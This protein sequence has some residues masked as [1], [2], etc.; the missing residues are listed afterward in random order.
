MQMI[1][2]MHLNILGVSPMKN[3]GRAF[4]PIFF[5]FLSGR[6]QSRDKN[7]KKDFHSIPNA[8]K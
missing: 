5:K 2:I 6:A 4:I 3:R 1:T 8:K 7:L